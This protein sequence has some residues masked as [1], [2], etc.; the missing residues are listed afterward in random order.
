M[1]SPFQRFDPSWPR[2]TSGAFTFTTIFDSKSRPAFMSMN[3]C[4][5]RAK[6]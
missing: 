3:V 6:Q 2:N 4:V 1:S 5:V